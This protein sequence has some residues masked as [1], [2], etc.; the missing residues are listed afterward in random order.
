MEIV[1]KHYVIQTNVFGAWTNL[2]FEEYQPDITTFKSR[3][4]VFLKKKGFSNKA[5]DTM[6]TKNNKDYRTIIRDYTLKETVLWQS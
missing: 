1:T 4:Q 3:A 2:Y 5:I 6:L